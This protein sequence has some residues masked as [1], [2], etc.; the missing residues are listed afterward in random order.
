[1]QNDKHAHVIQA[2]V[3][4]LLDEGDVVVVDDVNATLILR[5]RLP[6]VSIARWEYYANASGQRVGLY[7]GRIM[8]PTFLASGR[9]NVNVTSGSLTIHPVQLQDSGVYTCHGNSTDEFHVTVVGTANT[10]SRPWRYINLLTY[11][12]TYF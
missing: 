1:M 4:V 10:R 8:S 3:D 9:F 5:C 6:S 7:N 11:L 2:V 12:L